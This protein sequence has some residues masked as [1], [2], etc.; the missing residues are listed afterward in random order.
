MIFLAL[1]LSKLDDKSSELAKVIVVNDPMEAPGRC[2]LRDMKDDDYPMGPGSSSSTSSSLISP[3]PYSNSF[4]STSSSSSST[5]SSAFFTSG[6]PLLCLPPPAVGSDGSST[7]PTALQSHQILSET[8]AGELNQERK[9]KKHSRAGSSKGAADGEL[10]P[11]VNF[12]EII[13]GKL[14]RSGFPNENNF[15]FLK[16]LK[17]KSIL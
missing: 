2:E 1:E 7:P 8:L 9:A 17:L 4:S 15:E 16:G 6:P 10:G 14:Y 5:I 13:E 12:S 11:P 3:R